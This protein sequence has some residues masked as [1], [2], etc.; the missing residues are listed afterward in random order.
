MGASSNRSKMNLQEITSIG[1]A[2]QKAMKLVNNEISKEELNASIVKK[3]VI[4]EIRN[5]LIIQYGANKI[6]SM[7]ANDLITMYV[8]NAET[9]ILNF[10]TILTKMVDYLDGIHE[11]TEKMYE[12]SESIPL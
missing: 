2:L 6:I 11:N 12:I 5:K 8:K 10:E 9:R 1:D 7:T 3:Q 4:D